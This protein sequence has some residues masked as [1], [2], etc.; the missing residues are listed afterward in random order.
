MAGKSAIFHIV[1]RKKGN[2]WRAAAS[3][4]YALDK[5]Y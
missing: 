2:E 4:D 5:L 3:W 1:S